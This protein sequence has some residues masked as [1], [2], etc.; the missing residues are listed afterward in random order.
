MTSPSPVWVAKL[1]SE[2]MN[3][4][5]HSFL[6]YGWDMRIEIVS[7]VGRARTELAAFDAALVDAGIANYN[8]IT[9]SSVIPAGAEIVETDERPQINGNWGDRLYQVMAK[10]ETATLNVEIWAGIGWV[11]S[12]TT[13][14][15][16]FVEHHGHTRDEVERDIIATLEEMVAR[17]ETKFGDVQMSLRGA[18]CED[19]PVCVLV[20]A[21]YE[22]ALWESADADVAVRANSEMA[23]TSA[24]EVAFA[25]AAARS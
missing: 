3:A 18:V 23:W 19:Q 8:L 17:R 11:V 6:S 15:G 14:Q 22:T 12:E 16:L 13:G 24:D 20:S 5:T 10:S 9:L 25:A 21:V 1:H 2:K 7:G 4:H